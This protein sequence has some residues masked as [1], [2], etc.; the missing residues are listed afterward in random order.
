MGLGSMP[1]LRALL[2]FLNVRLG[3]WIRRPD[4]P[5][6]WC[7]PK[8]QHPGFF[9]LLREMFGFGMEEKHRWLNLSDGGHLENLAV[10]ELLRRRCKF[11][12][13]VV[14]E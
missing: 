2:A 11:N 10:Y 8:W 1:T 6:L 9:C 3:F 5:K 13:C 14:G 12:I 4:A 7:F